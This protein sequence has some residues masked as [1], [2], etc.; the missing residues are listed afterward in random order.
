MYVLQ[1]YVSVKKVQ[2]NEFRYAILS[3]RKN[4]KRKFIAIPQDLDLKYGKRV[5]HF[6]AFV[7]FL[8][9]HYNLMNFRRSFQ[10]ERNF[11]NVMNI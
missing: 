9:G 8:K 6:L 7:S 10:N 5:E 3:S 2:I 1:K 4:E 11:P